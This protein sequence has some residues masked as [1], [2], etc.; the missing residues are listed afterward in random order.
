[1]CTGTLEHHDSIK[2]LKDV[3][4]PILYI[5]G[6]YDEVLPDT[7]KFYASHNEQTEISIIPGSGHASANEAPN[8]VSSLIKNFVSKLN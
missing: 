5:A 1:M 4:V 6:E 7:L 8:E 2:C 3:N